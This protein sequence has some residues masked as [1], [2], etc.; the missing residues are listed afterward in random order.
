[1][2]KKFL[3]IFFLL[4][5][6]LQNS[7][8]E[9]IFEDSFLKKEVLENGLTIIT[10][11]NPS[12]E[13]VTCDVWVKTGSIN[14]TPKN[15]GIS[16]FL[17]HL[18]FKGT[19]KWK[20][21]EIERIVE[22]VGGD[23]NGSTSRDFTHYYITLPKEYLE[24][25]LEILSDMLKNPLFPEEE[26]ER[27]RNV[28]LEEI[29]RKEDMPKSYL[30]TL[31]FEN[32]FLLHPYKY[33][34]LGKPESLSKLE[35]KDFLNYLRKFYIPQNIIV[36]VVGNIK[37][38]DVIEKVKKYFSNFPEAKPQMMKYPVEPPQNE[39]REV[40]LEKDITQVYIGLAYHAPS[41]KD[42]PDVYAMDLILTILGEGRSSRLYQN[43]KI[44]KQLVTEVECNFLTQRYPGLFY[45]IC[46]CEKGKEKEV[47]KELLKEIE[48]L[49]NENI[50]ESELQK[51][52]NLVSS[53]VAFDTETNSGKASF[54]GFYEAIDTIDFAT[55]YL[56]EINKI[57]SE[58][59][60]K[61]ANKY[62]GKENYTLCILLP[63]K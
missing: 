52:K 62:F 31:L 4:V 30:Q 38:K 1:V 50:S 53:I 47:V 19:K 20:A 8:A 36:V 35:R 32:S 43:L 45:I 26:I 46:V 61:C 22:G 55:S 5:V 39:K 42:I 11:E 59:I 44:K 49:K 14:E 17:E 18:L 2:I 24:L 15:S 33:P 58:E 21:G 29:Y 41:V 51:A 9:E 7:F 12:T 34:V 27:E 3:K 37:S 13:T 54:L 10:Y 56:R 28:I 6:F 16:H 48:R 60:K 57:K 40:K 23:L 25:A 63:K